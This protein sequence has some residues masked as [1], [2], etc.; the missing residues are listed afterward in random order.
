MAIAIPIA[1][2]IAIAIEFWM[3][4]R[5]IAFTAAPTDYTD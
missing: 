4:D 1:I 3:L 2:A 5:I